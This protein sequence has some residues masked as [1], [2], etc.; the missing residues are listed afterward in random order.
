MQTLRLITRSP[1]PTQWAKAVWPSVALGVAALLDK[2]TRGPSIASML[3]S[4]V[5]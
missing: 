2:S 5:F 4:A 1:E 3:L